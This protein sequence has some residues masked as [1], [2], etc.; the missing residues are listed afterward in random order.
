MA[1]TGRPVEEDEDDTLTG[2]EDDGED[3]YSPEEDADDE[4]D[5][6]VEGNP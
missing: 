5:E 6:I 3:E 4:P 2:P 1:D